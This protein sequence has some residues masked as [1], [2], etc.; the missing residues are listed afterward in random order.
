MTLKSSFIVKILTILIAFNAGFVIGLCWRVFVKGSPS[1]ILFML[2]VILLAI[3][4]FF[5]NLPNLVHNI[6][7][8][9]K[10]K[11]SWD[12]MEGSRGWC[13]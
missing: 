12:P 9:T 1:Y 3:V 5:S 4:M 2:V 7:Y 13:E 11:I 6:F 10:R 8:H